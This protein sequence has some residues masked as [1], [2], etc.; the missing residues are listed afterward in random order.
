MMTQP[1]VQRC[2]DDDEPY[3]L[4]QDG[5]I[6]CAGCGN[7]IGTMGPRRPDRRWMYQ[8]KATGK[9]GKVVSQP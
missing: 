7:W 9:P 6:R 2:P 1:D 8:A 5:A 4:W 3:Q